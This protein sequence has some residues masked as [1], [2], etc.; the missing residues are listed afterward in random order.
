MMA[1]WQGVELATVKIMET[2]N[3]PPNLGVIVAV[4]GSV[5]D[6]WFDGPLPAIYAVLRSGAD[7]SV[8]MEVLEQRDAHNVRATNVHCI[9]ATS[10][11]VVSIFSCTAIEVT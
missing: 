3:S 9:S 4:R 5:V 1:R 8:V 11:I 7:R 10:E 6:A 2:K